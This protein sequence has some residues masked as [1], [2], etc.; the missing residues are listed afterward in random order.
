[1]SL[2]HGVATHGGV[3]QVEAWHNGAEAWL[4]VRDDGPAKP[5]AAPKP[6]SGLGLSII[7]TLAAADLGGSFS[8]NL[9]AEWSRA[10]VRWPYTPPNLME[11]PEVVE[12]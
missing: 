10:Q 2:S 1:N 9:D 6:S 12:D 11:E 8:L 3:V 5:P 4:E 7:E